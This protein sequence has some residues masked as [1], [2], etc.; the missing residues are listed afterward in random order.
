M[1]IWLKLGLLL[2]FLFSTGVSA[3]DEYRL[4]A[5][6][7]ENIKLESLSQDDISALQMLDA[8]KK[9]KTAKLNGT[10]KVSYILQVED[11]IHLSDGQKRKVKS[12]S[13]KMQNNA[14]LLGTEL[15]FLEKQLNNAFSNKSINEIKL[16]KYIT[17]IMDV[18]AKL[19][20]V[21]LSTRLQTPSIL[22]Q[23]EVF[24][25]SSLRTYTGEY[26]DPCL[27]TPA[28]HNVQM[29]KQYNGCK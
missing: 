15:I 10:Y 23:E 4:D 3:H 21:H 12:E 6:V 28:G 11:A 24:L 27:K 1:K 5:L 13:F 14:V 22:R 9:V 7:Q 25:Y 16:D 26:E 18:R 17:N 29:W 8:G 19:R 20:L 2:T